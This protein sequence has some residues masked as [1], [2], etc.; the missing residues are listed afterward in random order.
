MTKRAYTYSRYSHEDSAENSIE[1]QQG[2]QD[3]YA[4]RL[5][6]EIVDRFADHAISGAAIFNRPSMTKLL[7]VLDASNIDILLV[8]HLDRLTRDDGDMA[9]IHKQLIFRDIELHSVAQNGKVDRNTASIMALVGRNQLE[10]TAHAVR[11]GQELMIK[12]GRNTGGR[13][14]G[15]K[16]TPNAGELIIDDGDEA[17][18]GEANIVRRIYKY[19]LSGMTPRD[20]AGKLNVEGVPSPTGSKWNAS[21]L[22]GSK[23]RKYGILRN[24]I[25]KGEPQ[26][27]RVRMVKNP[28][29]GKRVSRVNKQEDII[30][31]AQPHLAIIDADTFE[32]VQAMFPQ[33]ENEH[34]SKYRRATTILTGLLKC[35]Y[36]GGGMSVKDKYKSRRRIQCST[37]KESRS[38]DNTSAYYLDE[39]VEAALSGLKEQLNKP[40]MLS[41]LIKSY[42]SERTLLASE[43]IEKT[44]IVDHKIDILSKKEEK[45]WADYDL[46]HFDAV[47]A[48]ERIQKIRG[49]IETLKEQKEVLPSVSEPVSIHPSTVANF[50][51]YIDQLTKT[52]ADQ[53]T[54]ENREAATAI[55]RLIEKITI[56]P[57]KDG[58]DIKIDGLLGLLA[59]AAS[60]EHDLG[61][62]VVAGEG[63]EPPT[64]G[65]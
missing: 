38:C 34:P 17:S 33:N 23:S 47:L 31:S 8:D 61:G 29:T 6:I 52:Y 58:T 13:A 44:K 11:R 51:Q 24:S 62:L 53:I 35:G 57:T 10:S 56:T 39:I 22:N 41:K 12:E 65:L 55:R 15:Y 48:S 28:S 9:Y 54:D 26:W 5:G 19:R 1:G 16:L 42:N 64:R 45:I 21:T 27:N 7:Q 32:R 3:K 50:K 37:M 14:Y 40:E 4:A 49:E 60:L 25:Y 59:S 2:S 18:H 30:T 63:L 46:G 43:T 20:I 36:C